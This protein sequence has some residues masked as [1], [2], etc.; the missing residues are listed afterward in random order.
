MY[1]L[2]IGIPTYNRNKILLRTVQRISDQ[3]EENIELL[4]IDNNS[5]IPVSETL[6]ITNNKNIRIIKNKTNIGGNANLLRCAEE[7]QGEYLW[8]LGDDDLPTNNAFKY[9]LDLLESDKDFLWLNFKSNDFI[10]QPIRHQRSKIY[11]LKFF[12][13]SLSSINELVFI[14]NNVV[15]TELIK[16]GMYLSLIHI[17]EPTRRS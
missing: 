3:L 9:I 17:S 5:D 8:V 15:K 1:K 6:D 14:S 7:A 16:Q 11:T 2:T 13:Q 4:I 12:L 10:N